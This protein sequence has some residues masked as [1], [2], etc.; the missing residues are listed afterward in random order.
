[1]SYSPLR[2][3]RR[4]RSFSTLILQSLTTKVKKFLISNV[5]H[6]RG[7]YKLLRVVHKLGDSQETSNRLETQGFKNT[8]NAQEVF[9]T[10]SRT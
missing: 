1:V 10:S 6:K 7:D 5:A 4:A 3:P 9:A 8:K 2:S